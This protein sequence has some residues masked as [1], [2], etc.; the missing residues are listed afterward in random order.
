MALTIYICRDTWQRPE[1][2]D[3]AARRRST[4]GGATAASNRRAPL[5]PRC[6]LD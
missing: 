1:T 6:Q 3:R 2:L 5:G 4:G